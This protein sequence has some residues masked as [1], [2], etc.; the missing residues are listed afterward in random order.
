M[1]WPFS[2][3]VPEIS[4]AELKQ[5]LDNQEKLQLIDV[6]EQEEYDICYIKE[7]QL[8]PMNT[9]E[10]ELP[11]WDKDALYVIQCKAGGRSARIVELMLSNGFKDVSNLSGGILAW[12]KEIEPEMKTY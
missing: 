9:V 11:D 2:K 1:K 10:R 4:V 7:A 5:K 6:R 12:A 3:S 8:V